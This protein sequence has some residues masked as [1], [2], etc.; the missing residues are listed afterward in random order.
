MK[1]RSKAAIAA[2]MTIALV[3]IILLTFLSAGCFSTGTPENTT[4]PTW[5]TI[6]PTP[7]QTQT[8]SPDIPAMGNWIMQS[9]ESIT[10]YNE[11]T[12]QTESAYKVTW[13]VWNT[14]MQQNDTFT[15]IRLTPV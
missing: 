9:S 3:F 11:T 7:T 8:T 6:Q 5:S 14:T 13:T 1:S 12:N 2:F 4:M 15:Q 10:I